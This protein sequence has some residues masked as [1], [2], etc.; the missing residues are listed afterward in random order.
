[1]SQYRCSVCGYIH[2]EDV[3]GSFDIVANCPI[4][5]HQ[6][7]E[8]QLLVN[9]VP[10]EPK[11]PEPEFEELEPVDELMPDFGA[12][13]VPEPAFEPEPAPVQEEYTELG[14]VEEFIKPV[15]SEHYTQAIR[16]MAQTGV[17]APATRKS[18]VVVPSWDDIFILGSQLD[19]PPLS[20]DMPVSTTTII[21]KSARIPLALNG[22]F[23]V[24]HSSDGAMPIE[25]QQALSE[26]CARVN[27]AICSA[28]SVYATGNGKFI[29]DCPADFSMTSE[30]LKSCNAIEISLGK[31]AYT[32]S[33]TEDLKSLV[34]NFKDKSDG[35]PV[36]VKIA[37]GRIEKDLA[38][39]VQA[40]PDFITI[41][42]RGGAL[43]GAPQIMRDSLGMP[44]IFALSRAVKFLKSIEYK[45]SLIIAGGLR[46]SADFAKALALGA[47]A[48][49]IGSSALIALDSGNENTTS[50]D[51]V[52][53]FISCS[54]EE[55]KDFARMTGHN[56]VHQ[57]EV[58]DLVTVNSEI[59]DHTD[60][61]HA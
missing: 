33:T 44:A 36:G 49:A 34:D 57:F 38:F 42:A 48:V 53:N 21:G 4:C 40:N 58:G 39:I 59:S 24:S 25:A 17:S 5:H 18:S 2:D 12:E 13:P 47:D 54:L 61:E 50:A 14:Y 8:F 15:E 9:G 16:V 23:F 35:L 41:D 31:G 46:T 45:T 30:A 52:A 1:M 26:G 55:L 28:E 37:T 60:I 22:P 6:H 19:P 20:P 27:T 7:E 51:A 32:I 10:V 29:Y 3:M 56:S 43:L 11:T